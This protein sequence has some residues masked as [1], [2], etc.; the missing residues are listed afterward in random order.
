MMNLVSKIPHLP[1]F[2]IKRNNFCR[3][4][5]K[6]HFKPF[7]TA[8]PQARFHKNVINKSRE[9]LKIVDFGLQNDPFPSLWE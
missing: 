7:F 9:K 4:V 8:C 6:T 2:P 3:K 5:Q 1:R